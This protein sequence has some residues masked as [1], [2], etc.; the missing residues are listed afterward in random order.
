MTS[1]SQ[2][3]SSL[4]KPR[5]RART[6]RVC[7]LKRGVTQSF[8]NHARDKDFLSKDQGILEKR[9]YLNVPPMSAGDARKGSISSLLQERQVAQRKVCKDFT[10]IFMRHGARLQ[11]QNTLR[12][13]LLAL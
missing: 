5:K 7:L 13:A 10:N 11:Y 1:F 3:N 6:E 12:K 2:T 8:K 4:N 9:F